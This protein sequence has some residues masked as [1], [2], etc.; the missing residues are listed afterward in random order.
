MTKP[1]QGT[2]LQLRMIEKL[3][4]FGQVCLF[5]YQA[6]NFPVPSRLMVFSLFVG[7]KL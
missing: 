7:L 5:I 4:V 3:C 2:V 1:I 6:L